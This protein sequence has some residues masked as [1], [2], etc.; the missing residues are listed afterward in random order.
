MSGDTRL[1]SGERDNRTKDDGENVTRAVNNDGEGET[2]LAI[3]RGHGDSDGNGEKSKPAL[4]GKGKGSSVWQCGLA[5]G[6]LD[7]YT[8]W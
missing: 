5:V 1:A 3:W 4:P 7:R 8:R 2:M 6:R